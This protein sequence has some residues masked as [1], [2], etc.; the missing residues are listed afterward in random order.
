MNI[1]HITPVYP[2]YT[3]G[4]GSVAHEYALA[5]ARDNHDVTVFTPKYQELNDSHNEIEVKRLKPVYKW[6]NAALIPQLLWELREFDILHL[7]YTFYGASLFTALAA[8]IW[9]KPLIITYHMKPIASGWLGWIFRIYRLLVE[10]FVFWSAKVVCAS[11]LDYAQS[12]GLRPKKLVELPFSVDAERFTPKEAL[13]IREELA[14]SRDS[15]AIIFVGGLDDAHYFKGVDVLIEACA[16]LA[17]D[18]DWDLIIVGDGNK[19]VQYQ[20]LAVQRRVV[21]KI[22]FVGRLS[23]DD[24]PR[25]YQAADVHVLPA[26]NR[27]E[28]F[29]LV[30]LEAAA[31]GLP[32]V[33][34]NL[35]GVRTLVKERETGLVVP[36]SDVGA[37]ILALTFMLQKDELRYRFGKAA[38]ER[39]ERRFAPGVI[40]KELREVYRSVVG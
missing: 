14:I 24:L 3:G 28:A 33:V 20:E 37:L 26:I 7:H 9:R 12:V 25:Y 16:K 1:A 13:D 15:K 35:P 27:C 34:S 40:Y 22:H 30:T 2:P 4:I 18:I 10:P 19:K 21:N 17:D 29:G 6:G 31:S 8:L 38:R 23:N 5:L 32:S 39:V 36:P 11:S